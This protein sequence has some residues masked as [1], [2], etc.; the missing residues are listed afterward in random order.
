MLYVSGY[1]AVLVVF[2]AIDAVWLSSMGFATLRNWTLQLTVLDMAYGAVASGA[3]ATAAYFVVRSISG[4]L[5]GS[6]A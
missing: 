4:W 3:A 1:L 2:G 5:G 6:S